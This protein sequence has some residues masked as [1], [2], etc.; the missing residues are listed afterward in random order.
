MREVASRN[1]P[2]GA[3][4]EVLTGFGLILPSGSVAFPTAACCVLVVPGLEHEF[5]WGNLSFRCNLPAWSKIQR[6]LRE[7]LISRPTDEFLCS[8]RF[9]NRRRREPLRPNLTLCVVFYLLI[10]V[11]FN[12]NKIKWCHC[13]SCAPRQLRLSQNIL[14]LV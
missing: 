10:L 3:C 7:N 13:N 12:E 1:K 9:G 8:R 14:S 11:Q 5:L 4:R 6:L 2:T